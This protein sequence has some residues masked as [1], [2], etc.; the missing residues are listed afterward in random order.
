MI[1]QLDVFE[2]DAVI[3]D[4]EDSVLHYDKDAARQLVKNYLEQFQQHDTQLFVRL[5]DVGSPYF[6]QDITLLETTNIQGYVLPKAS[7]ESLNELL[8][9]TD[10]AVIPIIEHPLAVL[11]ASDIAKMKQVQGLLLGAEDLTKE[12]NIKRTPDGV[13]IDY[14]RHHIAMVCQA[15]QIEAIDTPWVQKDNLEGL[16]KDAGY[17]KSIGFT[18]K[19]LIHPNH[20]EIANNIFVPTI[21]EIQNARRI[22]E[23]AKQS[24][25]GAFSLDG[26]MIDLP[27]IE[28]AQKLLDIAKRYHLV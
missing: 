17:A 6:E 22:I 27:V 13:E 23:K 18:G 21:E 20:V 12:M 11:G 15:Y 8:K 16:Q 5:N 1:Q 4:L 7:V 9:R 26:K 28:R 25:K 10:K 14:A 2:S 19:A 24:G 3:L